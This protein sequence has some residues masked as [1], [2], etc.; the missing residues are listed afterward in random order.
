MEPIEYPIKPTQPV[1]PFYSGDG[2]IQQTS[3]EYVDY[4]PPPPPPPHI[5]FMPPP[6]SQHKSTIVVIALAGA[7]ILIFGASLLFYL[8]VNSQRSTFRAVVT[9]TAPIVPTA[10]HNIV[11]TPTS[12][13]TF[14]TANPNY[15]ASDIMSD[16]NTAGI[17][18][19]Y[20]QYGQ[21]IWSWTSDLYYVSVHAVSSATFT[22]DSGCTGYCSPADLGIWVYSSPSEAHTAYYEVGNDEASKGSIPMIGTPTEYVHGRCLLLGASLN[23]V[24]AQVTTKKC[25]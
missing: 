25:V 21:T 17:R 22:D 12:A 11:A 1:I 18:P 2:L 10:A 19:G 6:K 9:S 14:S 5:S 20:V 7:A 8:G 15:T 16:F 3:P 13:S 4:I 24:Y 23:S